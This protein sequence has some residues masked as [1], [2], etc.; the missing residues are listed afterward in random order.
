MNDLLMIIDSSSGESFKSLIKHRVASAIPFFCK[1]RLIDFALSNAKNSKITNVA[2]FP[3]RN[4]LSLAD[5]IGSGDRWDL[6][7]RRDGIFILPTKNQQPVSMDFISF[8]RMYE[9]IEFFKRSKQEYVFITSGNIVWNVDV[10]EILDYHINSEVEITEII[11][12]N[13]KRIKSF[14]LKKSLLMEY[15][16]KYDKIMYE[17]L[18]QVYDQVPNITHILHLLEM[19]KIYIILV[20]TY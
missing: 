8:Q 10:N 7:R 6:D 12:R 3:Y 20:C 1:Y 19:K 17:N 9:H 4:Y 18:I 13:N 15:I 16:N 2:I 11:A 5:H 14:I